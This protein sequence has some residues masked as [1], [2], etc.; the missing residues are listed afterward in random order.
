VSSVIVPIV[1][2]EP[3]FMVNV[4]LVAEP[5]PLIVRHVFVALLKV[6]LTAYV[7][8]STAVMTLTPLE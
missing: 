5:I 6:T 2:P 4:V 7:E 3:F 1:V 8:R